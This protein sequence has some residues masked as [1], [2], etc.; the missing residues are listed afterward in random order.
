MN[1]PLRVLLCVESLY[2]VC[3]MVVVGARGVCSLREVDPEPARAMLQFA[4]KPAPLSDSILP[5][6]VAMGTGG[7][8]PG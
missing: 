6:P 4:E 7:R 2:S 3:V 8:F 1:F 5:V